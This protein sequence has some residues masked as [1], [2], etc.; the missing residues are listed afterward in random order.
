[1]SNTRPC[2]RIFMDK[3][4]ARSILDRPAREAVLSLPVQSLKVAPGEAIIQSG[5][6]VTHSCL[7]A[8]G[9]TGRSGEIQN[10][11]KQFMAFYIR[12]D[13]PDLQSYVLPYAAFGL[14][15]VTTTEVLTIEHSDLRRVC[16]IGGVTEAFWRD[17]MVDAAMANQWVINI[18]RR[19]AVPRIAH[20][21]CEF[22]IRYQ[23]L[24]GENSFSF[25]LPLR[26]TD[27]ADATGLSTVHVNRS[28]QFLK[29][30]GLMAIEDRQVF[31]QDWQRLVTLAEFD[32]RY[33]HL[34]SPASLVA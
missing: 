24:R 26:Q 25:S 22:A 32:A 7:I 12:G 15:A 20:L 28:L 27:I 8:D 34:P 33:L 29:Q 21:T 2:L 18:G 1:M 16:E 31:I 17:C 5:Q 30:A 23:A 10:G 19:Q 13:V 3:L 11:K 9:I 14:D 6:Y 4:L